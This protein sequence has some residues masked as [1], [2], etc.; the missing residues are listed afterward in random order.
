MG[1]MVVVVV[2]G[3]GVVVIVGVGVVV[4]FLSKGNT[5]A[6]EELVVSE[7]VSCPNYCTN[8]HARARSRGPTTALAR[9]VSLARPGVFIR[10]LV[11][12]LGAGRLPVG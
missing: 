8:S 2:V 9:S 3:V 5:N 12:L 6:T 10:R 11:R 7:A 4:F 1:K